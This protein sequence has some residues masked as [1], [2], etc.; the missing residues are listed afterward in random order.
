[1]GVRRSWATASSASRMPVTS[2]SMRASMALETRPSSLRTSPSSPTG[3]RASSR[4]VWVMWR[5]VSSSSRT[6]RNACHVSA[7]PPTSPTTTTITSS[8]PSS[9][10]TSRRNRSRSSVVRP[11]CS[12]RAVRQPLG[13]HLEP[14][15]RARAPARCASPR[16]RPAARAR[17]SPSWRA[18]WSAGSRRSM[19]TSRTN[20]WSSLP[21]ACSAA[22]ARPTPATP[23]LSKR[24]A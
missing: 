10:R 11:T 23:A 2:V 15:G 20:T 21:E 5:S 22:T 4:P 6:G 7:P 19:P 14:H 24:A 3:T 8:A 12:M 1:M 13:G 9:A 17:T 18:C 16:R